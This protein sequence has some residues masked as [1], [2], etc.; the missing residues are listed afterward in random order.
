MNFLT[1]VAVTATGVTAHPIGR[2]RAADASR[3]PRLTV[4]ACFCETEESTLRGGPNSPVML[5]HACFLHIT[6][7]SKDPTKA[8][9][10]TE[11]GKERTMITLRNAL[12]HRPRGFTLIELLVV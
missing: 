3:N 2:D 10:H 6:H 1:L 8:F 9:G 11:G 5:A 12:T 4:S 7:L